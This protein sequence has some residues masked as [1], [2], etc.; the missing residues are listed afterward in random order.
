MLGP[1]G[2]SFRGPYQRELIVASAKL[3]FSSSRSF[4]ATF[5]ARVLD[6]RY[7][8]VG[9]LSA[10]SAVTGFGPLRCTIHLSGPFAP[11]RVDNGCKAGRHNHALDS[12][13]VLLGRLEVKRRRSAAH[14]PRQHGDNNPLLLSRI[15]GGKATRRTSRICAIN[16][17]TA[18]SASW[19]VAV[20]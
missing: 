15:S 18:F 7:P 16:K 4:H 2:L 19:H 6:A 20:G 5:S 17:W 14:E 1:T 8:V 11:F 10:S 9:S 13:C 3:G 12:R